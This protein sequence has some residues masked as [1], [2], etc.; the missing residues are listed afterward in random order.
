MNVVDGSWPRGGIERI[1]S[2]S[3]GVVVTLTTSDK[4][5]VTVAV[6]KVYSRELFC[7]GCKLIAD[8]FSVEPLTVSEKYRT[9]LSPLPAVRRLKNSN[10]GGVV[11]GTTEDALMGVWNTMTGLE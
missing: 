8:V 4:T 2:A 6:T 3:T 1:F 5:G 9:T 10:L 7:A 11:S